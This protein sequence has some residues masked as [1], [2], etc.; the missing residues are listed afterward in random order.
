MKRHFLYLA[1]VA[2]VTLTF[3]A[4]ESNT[5]ESLSFPKKHLIE[6]FTGQ[7]CGYC[8]YGMD[9]IHEFVKDDEN[10]IVVLHHA[11]YQPDNFTVAG[12]STITKAMG[13]SGAPSMSIDRTKADMQDGA[14]LV[15]HP[16]YLP[17]VS[18]S[19]FDATTYASVILE[20]T[21]DASSRELTISVSGTVAK[22][23]LSSMKLTVLVKESG[24]IDYQSDYY[25]TYEGWSEFRHT[26]AV[27][28]FLTDAK[29]DDVTVSRNHYSQRYTIT[30]NEAWVP[31]N[32]MVV[33]FLGETFK[34]VVQAEQSPVVAD[35]KGGADIEHGGITRVPV[36]DYYPEPNATDGPHTYSGTN[37]IEITTTVASYKAYPNYG[38]NLWNLMGYTSD[39]SIKVG[40]ITSIPLAYLYLFTELSQDTIPYGTY[41]LT[42]TDQPGTAQAGYRDDAYYSYGGSMFYYGSKS[43]FNRG[44]LSPTAQWLVV[45]GSITITEQGWTLVGHTLNGSDICLVGTTPIINQ[46]KQ[47][48]APAKVIN[49]RE[50]GFDFCQP[51]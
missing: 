6:E 43:Y 37:S 3:A 24:M 16:G 32:C 39:A 20:N 50:K 42:N 7:D 19:Q 11:G 51:E 1:I 5:S 22:N 29:G 25:N 33:A 12:S 46:G 40:N 38:V 8:P 36:A 2:F 48:S 4:C 18:K 9:C 47:Q 13:V 34:S 17:T 10:W 15:F 23:D 26:N 45:D 21:Y 30:L 14:Q 44:Y 49:R 31:E 28:A 35:T 41:E 27:R